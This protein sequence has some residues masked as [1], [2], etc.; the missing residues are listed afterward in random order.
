MRP[1][2]ARSSAVLLFVAAVS[3]PL[4]AQT[5][6]APLP[7]PGTSTAGSALSPLR[8]QREHEQR[9]IAHVR[10]H[11]L[12][13]GDGLA[14]AAD[15]HDLRV[16]RAAAPPAP[17]PPVNSPTSAFGT[18]AAKEAAT[19]Q[20]LEQ[21]ALLAE[22]W[23]RRLN[24]GT[25][26]AMM[27]RDRVDALA[28]LDS[29]VNLVASNASVADRE[30]FV[31]ALRSEVMALQQAVRG[32]GPLNETIIERARAVA[33]IASSGRPARAVP[34]VAPAG[35]AG[36][37]P[38]AGASGNPYAGGSPASGGSPAG[39][40][41]GYLAGDYRGSGRAPYPVPTPGSGSGTAP[42][43]PVYQAYAEPSTPSPGTAASPSGAGSSGPVGCFN[44]RK[45]AVE[46]MMGLPVGDG[47]AKGI[48]EML[49]VAECWANDHS[50]PGWSAQMGEAYSW[51]VDFAVVS[52][53][54]GRL[55][56]IIRRIRAIGP[57]PGPFAV[58]TATMVGIAAEADVQ[59]NWVRSRYGCS[60]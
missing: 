19:N 40:S 6:P 59:R 46:T 28:R 27:P 33:A 3:G 41:G 36:V 18:A 35:P 57:R 14:L 29:A 54:C 5:P 58:D 48:D 17:L 52:R 1:V 22:L 26:F 31:P 39:I 4:A 2:V 42:L 32:V 47:F 49:N 12:S 38:A 50:W 53:D 9:L 34:P 15:R 51:A 7:Y 37:G 43:P 8:V 25:P 30:R 56:T 45:Q 24:E 60:R 21:L 23:D 10:E 55:E 44:K 11:L 16:L 20:A 13:V